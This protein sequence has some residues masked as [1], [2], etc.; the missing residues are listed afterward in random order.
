VTSSVPERGRLALALLFLLCCLWAPAGVASAQ[1]ASS[2][3]AAWRAMNGPP[4]TILHLTLDARRTNRLWAVVA[5]RTARQ[6]DRSQQIEAGQSRMAFAVYR[7]EDGG[8]TWR[9][10]GNA[11]PYGEITA[12]YY[13][14][15]S[16]QLY[17]GLLGGGDVADRPQGLFRSGDGG[18]SWQKVELGPPHRR[19]EVLAIRRSK[20][21]AALFVGALETA[22]YPRSY[23]YRSDDNGATWQEFSA[24]EYE[25]YAG[26]TLTDLVLD[27]QDHERLYIPT[28]GGLSYSVD[29]ARTWR[30]AQLPPCSPGP[31]QM[32]TVSDAPFGA[33]LYLTCS[34]INDGQSRTRLLRSDD[35]GVTWRIVH[36]QYLP[37]RASAL[38]L[39][40]PG[41]TTLLLVTDRAVYR[42]TDGGQ[43]WR[44]PAQALD[45]VGA[46]SLLARAELGARLY[47]ATGHG[48]Y[49]ST[50]AGEHWAL[51]SAGLP[52]NGHITALAQPS[53]D[54]TTLYSALQWASAEATQWLVSVQ[55]SDDD[56]QSWRTLAT[57]P[58]GDALS[59]AVHPQQPDHLYV[60]TSQGLVWTRDGGQTW[61]ESSLAGHPVQALAFDPGDAMRIF[62]GTYSGGV[63]VSADGGLSWAAIG[64]DSFNINDLAV[65]AAGEVY[66]ATDTHIPGAGGLY[67]S[68][69]MGRTW[70]RLTTAESGVDTTSVRRVWLDS[71]G[72]SLL[73]TPADAGV[74][75]SIDGG[76][77]WLPASAGLPH[78]SQILE[79]L[80]TSDGT[81]WASRDGGGIYRTPNAGTPWQAASSGLGEN[82]A[83]DL[84]EQP[85]AS[86]GVLAATDSAGLWLWRTSEVQAPTEV[87]DRVDA[88]IEI[89]WPHGGAEVQEATKANIGLRLFWPGSLLPT[90]CDW[91]PQ[92]DVWQAVNTQAARRLRLATQRSVEGQPFPFWDLNDVDV[93]AAGDPQ[94]KLYFMV[95]V[96]GI[97][98]ATS[99]WAHGSDPRTYFP[100]QDTPAAIG[101]EAPRSVEARI[102]IVWPH[103]GLG[104]EQPVAAA[105]WANVTVALF[106]RG[107]DRSVPIDW[108]PEGLTLYGAWNQSIGQPLSTK[109][110]KRLE[111]RGAITFPVWDFNNIDVRAARSPANKLYLWVEGEGATVYPTIWAHGAD[112]R[113]Q[114]PM[115][116]EPIV[117]C[118]VTAPYSQPT[119]TA[120]YGDDRIA[121][122][123][124]AADV[125]LQT[126]SQLR[127]EVPG[128]ASGAS[129][130]E[131][132]AAEAIRAILLPGSRGLVLQRQARAGTEYVY[133]AEGAGPVALASLGDRV[134]VFWMQNG[135][136][137][138]QWWSSGSALWQPLRGTPAAARTVWGS[139]GLEL[140]VSGNTLGDRSWAHYEL[141]RLALSTGNGTGEALVSSHWELVWSSALAPSGT[142]NG[143]E[144][145]VQFAGAALE[146]LQLT[147]PLPDDFASAPR[148]FAEIDGHTTQRV[149]SL[150]ERRGDA[151]LRWTAQLQAT[152]LTALGRFITS[153]R[154]GDLESAAQWVSDRALVEQALGYGW[155]L[156]RPGGDRLL[157]SG[158]YLQSEGGPIDFS[159]ESDPSFRFRALFEGNGSDWR[160]TAIQ[161][162]P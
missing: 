151:Y 121:Y 162:V 145:Q 8:E 12:L 18:S 69:D 60:A 96:R 14:S 59:V 56:G 137:W 146:R 147:G 139:H 66:A 26:S 2:S 90:P 111:R 34:E 115:E 53:E 13:D 125:L 140:G 141:L 70:E 52:P 102:Q 131:A 40:T 135:Q 83:V 144:G 4:G 72:L 107:T 104:Q 36:L 17:A 118:G 129:L 23:V 116:D 93:I 51:S 114:F 156:P 110:E 55:R 158:G 134:Y 63:Y 103:D 28:Y 79:L 109:A 94:T 130:V 9:P 1:A 86:V 10:A 20:D 25:Q 49:V 43:T 76:A 161:P 33:R 152:P 99:I 84:V 138:Q 19:I 120:G 3:G 16:A 159:S 112:A 105:D 68:A 154:E 80:Q 57:G 100:M 89:L 24:L 95:R 136:L 62:A 124:D 155:S 64:L 48:L 81:F 126:L 30:Q 58:W 39:L 61:Q 71:R 11:L 15:P 47:A 78:N 31:R 45:I 87:P 123:G 42:S 85:G 133:V 6:R 88:R 74:Y 82:I 35:G 119:A 50:D 5:A 117:G 73:V 92:V 7:S 91:T 27:P 21:G 142:W 157:A 132:K 54:S 106:E 127:P 77:H 44:T 150:W 122:V 98:T 160:I 32:L 46:T 75:R 97:E 148:V 29:G 153:L 128:A 65:G 41:S 37:G 38:A 108:K 101:T 113:T 143:S 149:V 22:R 67:R